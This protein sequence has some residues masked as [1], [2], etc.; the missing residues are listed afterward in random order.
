MNS[1]RTNKTHSCMTLEPKLEPKLAIE[2]FFLPTMKHFFLPF[3]FLITFRHHTGFVRIRTDIASNGNYLE[4]PLSELQTAVL[5]PNSKPAANI[6]LNEIKKSRALLRYQTVV[7]LTNFGTLPKCLLLI[8][9][10]F[11]SLNPSSL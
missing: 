7:L 6:R 3:F 2:Y 4:Q 1:Q 11:S 8:P 10:I 9:S 5:R